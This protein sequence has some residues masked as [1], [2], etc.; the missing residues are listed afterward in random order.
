MIVFWNEGGTSLSGLN[1]TQLVVSVANGVAM[2]AQHSPGKLK[3]LRDSV[4]D[5]STKYGSNY[6]MRVLRP[7]RTAANL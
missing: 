2:V 5:V 3:R 7:T 1:H 4:S 6:I